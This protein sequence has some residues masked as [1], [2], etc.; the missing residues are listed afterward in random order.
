MKPSWFLKNRM[1]KLQIRCDGFSD[2]RPIIYLHYPEYGITNFGITL[3]CMKSSWVVDEDFIRRAVYDASDK[4]PKPIMGMMEIEY[5][6]RE[7]WTFIQNIGDDYM[8]CL[9]ICHS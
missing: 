9:F 7:I 2:G 1:E 6:T 4:Y 8:K 3:M 5:L